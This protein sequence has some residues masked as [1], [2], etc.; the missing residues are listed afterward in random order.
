MFGNSF[1]L[2]TVGCKIEN[3]F[4]APSFRS[5]GLY[6]R[7]RHLLSGN[8]TKLVNLLKGHFQINPRIVLKQGHTV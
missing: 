4:T 1:W 7:W 6:H 5:K 8:K 3:Q 2:H